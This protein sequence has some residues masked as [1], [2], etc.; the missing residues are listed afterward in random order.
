MN[1]LQRSLGLAVCSLFLISSASARSYSGVGGDLLEFGRLQLHGPLQSVLLEMGS[2]GQTRVELGLA[3]GESRELIVPLPPRTLDESAPRIQV[4]PKEGRAIFAGWV[5][6][7]ERQ[8]EWERHSPLLRQRTRPPVKPGQIRA[9]LPS[10]ALALAT[11]L[12][13]IGLRSSPRAAFFLACA[14][15]CGGV[16]LVRAQGDRVATRVRVMEGWG[17]TNGSGTQWL[18]ARSA[19]GPLRVEFEDCLRME[20]TQSG[21]L[22]WEVALGEWGHSQEAQLDNGTLTALSNLDPQNRRCG[23]D[24]NTWGAMDRV[25]TRAEDGSWQFHGAWELG[26]PLPDRALEVPAL[27][28]PPVL[29]GWLSA[30]LPMGKKVL[31]AHMAEGSWVGPSRAPGEDA[32]LRW[33]AWAP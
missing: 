6:G 30:G 17:A 9:T 13:V 16:G 33:V 11:A 27:G 5:N 2:A 21:R 1:T 14:L 19:A 31:V 32:W 28:V 24:L 26:E 25:W 22:R 20:G 29:P 7:D 12:L 18:L 8:L 23:P 10:L 3:A 4:H 15:C